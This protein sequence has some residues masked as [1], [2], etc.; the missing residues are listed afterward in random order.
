MNRILLAKDEDYEERSPIKFQTMP[1][2]V[3]DPERIILSAN[4]PNISIL[5]N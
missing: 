5:F 3:F 1:V 4:T 2:I